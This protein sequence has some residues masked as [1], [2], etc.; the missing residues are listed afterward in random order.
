MPCIGTVAG[1]VAGLV[2]A[3]SEP[4]VI[5]T[6][7]PFPAYTYL[8]DDGT[9]TGFER[10]LMDEICARALLALR[11]TDVHFDQLIPGVMAGRLDVVLGGIAVTPERRDLVDFTL[12]TS[13]RSRRMV[14][15]PPRRARSRSA[16][17]AVQSGTMH[18]AHLREMGYR[19]RAFRPNPRCWPH[20]SRARSTWR[21]GPFETREDIPTSSP[22]TVSI[23]STPRRS[24][25]GRRHGGLQGQHALAW[26]PE[27]TAL[28]CHPRR[29][30]T[31][32]PRKPLV[33]M[34][35]HQPS[36]IKGDNG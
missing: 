3:A 20:W 9:I 29:W 12:P 28:G 21:L 35:H 25:R 17:I 33:R 24:R 4:V 23:S 6:D 2:L 13:N 10:D 34:N 8:D 36:S 16:L 15:R 32:K 19:H 18:E 22:P 26:H 7:A 31:C 1:L 14:H 11:W 30:D 5:A 27:R